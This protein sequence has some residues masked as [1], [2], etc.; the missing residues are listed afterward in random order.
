MDKTITPF[1]FPWQGQALVQKG[2]TDVCPAEV[3]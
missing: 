3:I 2:V 1:H